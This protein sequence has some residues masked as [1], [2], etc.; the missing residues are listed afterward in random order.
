[1][2]SYSILTFPSFPALNEVRLDGLSGMYGTAYIVEPRLDY[3]DEV[4]L[5]VPISLP[6]GVSPS[7][8]VVLIMISILSSGSRAIGGLPSYLTSSLRCSVILFVVLY[9]ARLR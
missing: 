2:Y 5:G 6:L 3:F 9:L 1:M 8:T 7:K 4:P